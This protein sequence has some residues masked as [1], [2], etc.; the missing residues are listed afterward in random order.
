MAQLDRLDANRER[1]EALVNAR[2][3]AQLASARIPGAAFN[4][5]VFKSGASFVGLPSG[6]GE[7]SA[8]ADDENAGGSGG[9]R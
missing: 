9:A 6:A 8:D 2:V 7:Y 4:P 1:I 3:Q 5:V